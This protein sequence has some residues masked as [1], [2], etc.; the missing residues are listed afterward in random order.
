MIPATLYADSR[1]VEIAYK[2]VGEGPRDIVI[3]MP[4]PTHLDMLWELPEYVDFVEK[5]TRLGRTIAFDK[6]G[7]G[8]SDRQLNGI[9][10]EQRCRDIIAVMDA[11]GSA[12]AVLMGWVDS[13]R[14][15]LMTAA[16]YPQRVTAVIAGEAVAVGHRDADHPFGLNRATL[17]MVQQAIEHG[18]WGRALLARVI[19]PADGADPAADRR[20]RTIRKLCQPRPRPPPSCSG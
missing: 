18:A 4:G 17:R 14:V 2:V 7:T 1:G 3:S 16:L 6:R 13:A 8:L 15:C 19:N 11:A 10:P 12:E 9:T 5:V 20:V